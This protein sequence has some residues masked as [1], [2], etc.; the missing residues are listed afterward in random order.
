MTMHSNII[1][2]QP[3]LR[4][5]AIRRPMTLIRAAR[6]GQQGWRRKR[7]LRAL[8][9]SDT[10]PDPQRALPLLRDLENRQNKARLEGAADYD[11]RRHVMLLIAIL[12]ET[13]ALR[14]APISRE[15]GSQA[16]P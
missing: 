6:A 16:R 3:V 4:P 14:A 9:R 5:E 8:L 12:A 1:A 13:R 2:F 7:D 15:T 11:L 10:L